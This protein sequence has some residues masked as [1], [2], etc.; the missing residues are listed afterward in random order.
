MSLP[1]E[2]PIGVPK[3]RRK[4]SPKRDLE[5]P[6][7]KACLRYLRNHHEVLY[8]ERRNTGMVHFQGGGAIRFGSLGASDIWC[9]VRAPS[10]TQTG[11]GP[12]V[13]YHLEIE[14]KR[15]DGKGV[16]SDNQKVFRAMC[17][18]KQIP[19]IVVTSVDQVAGKINEFIS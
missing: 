5:G 4:R 15:S 17:L 12:E 3:K 11:C 19:Y 2:C 10:W 18:E 9:L 6:V 14:C 13:C 16:L 1:S 8:V 7:V